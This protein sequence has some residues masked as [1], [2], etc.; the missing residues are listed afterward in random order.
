MYFTTV[1][2]LSDILFHGW[3]TNSWTDVL[4]A[5]II[6]CTITVIFEGLKIAKSSLVIYNRSSLSGSGHMEDH[7][8]ES[9]V[10]SSQADLLSSLRIP[11]NTEN[12]RIRKT[13]LFLLESVL[14]MFNFLYGYIL[15]LLVMTYSVWF[16]LAV[17]L[18]SGVGFFICHPFG[19]RLIAQ[20]SS[21]RKTARSCHGGG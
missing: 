16:L 14:H 17:L 18:G 4:I 19:Q 9:E 3:N 2:E 8:Q 1:T 21:R 10:T 12:S 20:Y 5:A 6:I 7:D 13:V 15:M 11:V